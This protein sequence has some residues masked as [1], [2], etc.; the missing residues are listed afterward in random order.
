MIG[1][2][3][4]KIGMTRV[5]QEGKLVPCTTV[6]LGACVVTQVKTQEKDGYSAIQVA[7]GEKK[8]KNTTKPLKGHFKA[9]NTTPKHKLVEFR[10]YEKNY[11]KGPLKPGDPLEA[12]AIFEE[13]EFIDAVNKAKGKGFTGVMKRHGFGGVG[14]KTHGQHNRQRAPGSIGAGSTPSRVFK[15]LRMAGQKG[16]QRVK[17]KNIQ[18]LKIAADKNL[19]VLKGSI[20]GPKKSYIVLQK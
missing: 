20:P 12:T 5:F 4:R 16:G 1:I 6:Q 19:L 13:G 10:D 9:A 2:I 18:I 8:A 3:A 11:P 15:G 7:Y 17:M 14:D